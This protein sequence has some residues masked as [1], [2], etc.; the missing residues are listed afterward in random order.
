LVIKL[1]MRKKTTNQK[2]ADQQWLEQLNRYPQLK[3]RFQAILRLAASQEAGVGTADEIERRLFAEVR[4]LGRQTMGEWARVQA[5]R[6]EEE[7]RSKHP[8]GYRSKK[9]S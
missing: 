3:E 6:V 8:R 2:E 1:G 9:K 5:E 7:V 4:Q